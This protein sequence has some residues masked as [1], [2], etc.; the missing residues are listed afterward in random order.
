M[1]FQ[2]LPQRL[3]EPFGYNS[4]CANAFLPS[5]QYG[6]TQ[7][8]PLAS[9]YDSTASCILTTQLTTQISLHSQ[10]IP[11]PQL[12]SAAHLI[13]PSTMVVRLHKLLPHRIR[14][15]IHH[16]LCRIP[17]Y[18]QYVSKRRLK[19][20]QKHLP[21]PLAPRMEHQN[22][23]SIAINPSTNVNCLF[24]TM[25]PLEI[26]LQVYTEVFSDPKFSNCVTVH[27]RG[28]L[29]TFPLC[30]CHPVR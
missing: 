5:H 7:P 21:K 23:S 16:T 27:N 22:L 19:K 30:C 8:Q 6:R 29:H 26:R 20:R 14:R 28:H 13:H 15:R 9:E 25:L 11:S 24:L 2:G 17:Y 3:I 12:L 1:I 18:C 4:G 10:A